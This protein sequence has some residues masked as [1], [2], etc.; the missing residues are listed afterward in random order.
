[1]LPF[2]VVHLFCIM[3]LFAD[4][5]IRFIVFQSWEFKTLII[6]LFSH[7]MALGGSD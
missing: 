4:M 3:T 5:K 6:I 7:T 1:M 2:S